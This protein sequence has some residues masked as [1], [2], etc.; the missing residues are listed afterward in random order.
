M[1]KTW[2]ILFIITLTANWNT[3]PE[4]QKGVIGFGILLSKISEYTRKLKISKNGSVYILSEQGRYI[5]LPFD[6]EFHRT[7]AAR[8]Y[9]RSF[10]PEGTGRQYLAKMVQK[11][12]TAELGE[13]KVASLIIHGDEDPLIPMSGGKATAAAIPDSEFMI[14]KGM[15]HVIPNLNAYWSD[16][17]D[18]LINHMGKVKL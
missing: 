14:V 6:E 8:S 2:E 12:R 16:I 7:L 15:G 13:L 10:C 4:G 18:A 5:G 1:F 17:K 11:D 9:D 3:S